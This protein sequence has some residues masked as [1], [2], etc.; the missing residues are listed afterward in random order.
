LLSPTNKAFWR[1]FEI[2]LPG[3]VKRDGYDYDAIALAFDAFAV[4]QHRRFFYLTRA[5]A[6]IDVIRQV[7]EKRYGKHP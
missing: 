5:A 4:P 6:V 3:L 7:R 2:A 1:V